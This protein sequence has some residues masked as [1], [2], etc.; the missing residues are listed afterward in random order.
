MMDVNRILEADEVIAWLSDM[1]NSLPDEK[2]KGVE[3]ALALQ[4]T[5]S[6][7]VEFAKHLTGGDEPYDALLKTARGDTP[8]P[9]SPSLTVFRLMTA[10]PADE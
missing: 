3:M 1:A 6:Y 7:L 2:Q 9:E 5:R 10:K 4:L 8:L